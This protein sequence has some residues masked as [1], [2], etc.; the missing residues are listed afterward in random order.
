MTGN[1]SLSCRSRSATK[2]NPRLWS[3]IVAEVK[4]DD[5]GG[6]PDSWSARKAQLAVALYKKAGGGYI[7][8]KTSCNSLAQWT[9]EDW[10]YIS[11]RGAAEKKGRYLPRS[12]RASL[13]PAEKKRENRLK[14]TKWGEWVPY[15]K[16]VLEKMRR[17]KIL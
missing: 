15:S 2:S 14:S 1:Q 17:R 7:G 16:S 4:A 13:S 3:R 9:K 6:M 10:G 8:P 12:V 11:P 5:K